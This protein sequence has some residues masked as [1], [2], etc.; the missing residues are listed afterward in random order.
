M[1]INHDPLVQFKET[2]TKRE[3]LVIEHRLALIGPT[4]G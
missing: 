1:F 3:L 4:D 2:E